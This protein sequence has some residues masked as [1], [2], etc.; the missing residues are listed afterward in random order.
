MESSKNT[1]LISSSG[2]TILSMIVM[3]EPRV[4]QPLITTV[5]YRST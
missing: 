3:S 5:L 1:D 2:D 4:E